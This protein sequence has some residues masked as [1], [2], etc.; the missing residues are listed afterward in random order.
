ML[1]VILAGVGAPFSAPDMEISVGVDSERFERERDS[2]VHVL[3]RHS[4]SFFRHSS[5]Y[6]PTSA[7]R[8]WFVP[9][10]A[11]TGPRTSCVGLVGPGAA[12][13]GA[14]LARTRI[15]LRKGIVMT[16]ASTDCELLRLLFRCSCSWG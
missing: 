11:T 10:T 14:I 8:F 16:I 9:S 3:T 13:G 5:M 2:L 7:T 12:R 15:L 1:L 6:P 4:V